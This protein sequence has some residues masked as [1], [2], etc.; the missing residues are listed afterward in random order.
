MPITSQSIHVGMSSQAERRRNGGWEGLIVLLASGGFPVCRFRFGFGL[1]H[2]Q[3][4]Q[5]D[6]TS[7]RMPSMVTSKQ[8]DVL[9]CDDVDEYDAMA[10]GF[11]VKSS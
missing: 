1:L 4:Q 9:L 5:L 11:H 8:A 2:V 6:W 10:H 3:Q 7:F